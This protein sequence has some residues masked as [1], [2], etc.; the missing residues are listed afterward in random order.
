[1]TTRLPAFRGPFLRAGDAA[2]LALFAA[3]LCAYP[4]A[5]A[6]EASGVPIKIGLIAPLSGG[7]ARGAAVR[8]GAELAVRRINA[9]G[10]IAGRPLAL[11]ERDDRSMNE[12]GARAAEELIREDHVAAAVGFADTSVTLAAAPVFEETRTPLVASAV[13]GTRITRLFPPPVYAENYIFRVGA[14]DALQADMIAEHVIV[15]GFSKVAVFHDTTDDGR[16]GAADLLQALA[17]RG[18]RPVTIERFNVGDEDMSAQ[19]GRARDA[20]AEAILTYGAGP[21]LARIATERRTLGWDVSL[22]GSWNLALENFLDRAGPA[23]EGAAMPQ[24][25]IDDGADAR[26]AAFMHDIQAAVVTGRVPTP[27]AAAQS[28]DAV[29]LLAAA[30]RQAGSTA[31]PA[32]RAALENLVAPVEGAITRYEHPFTL[33]RHEALTRR[34]VAI[35]VVQAGRVVRDRPSDLP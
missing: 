8:A 28:Y 26:Q 15:R 1:M 9:E 5:R 24:T 6:D 31:G 2:A 14:E 12:E 7:V 18:I 35:G 10:G 19:L 34:D 20:G 17:Q 3:V 30:M 21:E 32:I 29:L 11:V 16:L 27:A 22:I 4:T 23:A 13:T 25:F 33:T